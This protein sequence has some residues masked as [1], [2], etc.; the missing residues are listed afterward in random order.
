MILQTHNLT[1]EYPGQTAM[2]RLELDHLSWRMLGHTRTEWLWQEQ[3]VACA[4][5]LHCANKAYWSAGTVAG[6]AAATPGLGASLRAIS[7]FCCRKSRANSGE[8][9]TNTYC[10]A[11]IRISRACLAGKPWT[12]KSPTQAI[13][14]MELTGLAHRPLVTLSGASVNARALRCCSHSRRMLSA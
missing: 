14:R 13:E 4:G 7:A 9:C 8:M 5:G 3:L 6:K 12:T 10:W 1:L 11:G 2:P